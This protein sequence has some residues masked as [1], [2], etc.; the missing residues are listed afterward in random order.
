M[1]KHCIILFLVA[2]LFI[3]HSIN[4]SIGQQAKATIS[5]TVVADIPS[6]KPLGGARVLLKSSSG[7]SYKKAIYT[8][9]SGNVK[10]DDVP[11]SNQPYYMGITVECNG[12][13]EKSVGLKIESSNNNYVLTCK[14]SPKVFEISGLV[15]DK[16]NNPI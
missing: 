13:H 6:M 14:L 7:P 16:A 5:I 12:F 11:L 1:K 3:L 15:K 8:D 9:K 10:F 4:Y 2:L